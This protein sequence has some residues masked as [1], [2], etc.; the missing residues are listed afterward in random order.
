MVKLVLAAALVATLLLPALGARDP[1]PARGLRRTLALA[2]A[3]T[4]AWGLALLLVDPR[5]A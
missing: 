4:L 3:F 2:L 5:I 1:A